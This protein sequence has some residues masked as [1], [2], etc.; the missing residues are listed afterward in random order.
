[1]TAAAKESDL[2][3]LQ[4]LL[5]EW[6]EPELQR[7]VSSAIIPDG[8]N[9]E[10]TGISLEHA[11]VI[12]TRMKTEGFKARRP[13]SVDGPD[14]PVLVRAPAGSQIPALERWNDRVCSVPG[15]PP[16]RLGEDEDFFT[17]L[18]NGHFTVALN[19]FRYGCKSVFTGDMYH[20]GNDSNLKQALLYGVPSLVLRPDIPVLTRKEISLLLNSMHC[21]FYVDV[22]AG[23]NGQSNE[24]TAPVKTFLRPSENGPNSQFDALSKTLDAEE[25]SI[26]VRT[27]LGIDLDVAQAGYAET[28]GTSIGPT[29][30]PS[31]TPTAATTTSSTRRS[32]RISSRL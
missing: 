2:K 1:M 11:H 7:V 5:E 24:A 10:R 20:A 32:T 18:G 25:L 3:R 15:Y 17:S 9:R 21:H 29:T 31:T 26:L 14:I 30:P 13:T 6:R 4:E 22:K 12:A 27:K 28:L 23:V 8:T 19:L 16:C